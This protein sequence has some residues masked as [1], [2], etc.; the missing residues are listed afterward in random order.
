MRQRVAIEPLASDTVSVVRVTGEIDLGNARDVADALLNSIADT[1]P[2]LVAELSGV[3]YIDSAGVRLLVDV[4]ERLRRNRQA[5]ALAIAPNSPIS[6]TLSI[7]KMDLLIP[8]HETVEEA[9]ATIAADAGA[10]GEAAAS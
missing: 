7:V 1:S 4:E 10:G 3:S 8:M 2:G 9:V 5:L 6:R